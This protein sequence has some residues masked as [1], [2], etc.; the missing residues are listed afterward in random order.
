M[1]WYGQRRLVAS[2]GAHLDYEKLVGDK[3]TVGETLL[4]RHN[5]YA[6]RRDVDGWDAEIRASANRPLGLTTL[7]FAY[8]TVERSWANDPGQAFWREG[9]GM[10]FL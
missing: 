2:V 4:V 6:R 9:L 5:D 7:G 8:A 10:G 3:W 1:R